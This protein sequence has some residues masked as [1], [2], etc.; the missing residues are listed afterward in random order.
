MTGVEFDFVVPDSVAA[1]T[2]YERFFRL[3]RL[4]VTSFERGLNEVVFTM[5]GGRF[6]MLDENP[7]YGLTA[8]IVGQAHSMWVNIVVP[9]IKVTFEAAVAAGCT[10]IQPL[11]EMEAFG[12]SNAVFSDPFGYVWMLHQIHREV[13]FEERMALF[14]NT[15]EI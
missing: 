4:E 10:V 3:E 1:L 7:E 13:S 6:H 5:Y 2:F 12:V 9:D 14:E 11:T 15:S 8:P